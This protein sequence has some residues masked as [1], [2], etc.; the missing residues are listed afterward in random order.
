MIIAYLSILGNS[1]LANFTLVVGVGDPGVG[2]VN[3]SS[4]DQQNGQNHRDKAGLI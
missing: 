3:N 4:D 2:N 1:V